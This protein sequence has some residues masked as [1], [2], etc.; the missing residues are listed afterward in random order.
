[1]S[2]YGTIYH[3]ISDAFSEF[4][5]KNSG[6]N[7]N[8]D[9]LSNITSSMNIEADGRAGKLSIDS[10]NAWIQLEGSAGAQD[11]PEDNIC[12]IYHSKPNINNLTINKIFEETSSVPSE[13]ELIEVDLSVDKYL[14][15][16][17]IKYDNAGHISDSGDTYLYFKRVNAAKELDEMRADISDFKDA[18]NTELNDF[19]E[20]LIDK[21]QFEQRVVNLENLKA[22]DTIKFIGTTTDFTANEAVTLCNGIGNIDYLRNNGKSGSTVMLKESVS[23]LDSEDTLCDYINALK[24]DLIFLKGKILDLEKQIANA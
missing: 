22:G 3:Q 8:N 15:I 20:R 10:G 16:N 17:N 5:I 24:S 4:F 12:K 23:D 13:K 14:K 9:F 7:K 2:F 19:D 18:V 6:V 11:S 21:E 1:M